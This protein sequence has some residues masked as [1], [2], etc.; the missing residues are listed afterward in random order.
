MRTLKVGIAS[1]EGMKKRTMAIAR[2]QL[3]PSKDDPKVWFTSP[4]SFAKVLSNKNRALLKVIV[5]TQPELPADACGTHGTQNIKSVAHAAHH[6]A[7]WLCPPASRHAGQDP[8]GS[9]L[10]GDFVDVSP[11]NGRVNGPETE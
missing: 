1:L 2:G 9:A 11:R 5:A 8:A 4:E 7:L 10:P 6:G 3:K